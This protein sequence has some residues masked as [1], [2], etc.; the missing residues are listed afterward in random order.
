MMRTCVLTFLKCREKRLK[1][2][3]KAQEKKKTTVDNHHAEYSNK[4][5]TTSGNARNDENVDTPRSD[6]RPNVIVPDDLD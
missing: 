4:D 6:S 3:L 1:K 5:Y 2:K